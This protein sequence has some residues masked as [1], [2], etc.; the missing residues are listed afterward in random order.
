MTIKKGLYKIF[1][2]KLFI[3][4]IFFLAPFLLLEIIEHNIISTYKST[5]EEDSPSLAMFIL[6]TLVWGGTFLFFQYKRKV[7]G[8]ATLIGLNAVNKKL[9]KE[10]VDELQFKVVELEDF[11]VNELEEAVRELSLI[12]DK[13]PRQKWMS[14]KQYKNIKLNILVLEEYINQKGGNPL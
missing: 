6:M 9:E 7:K 11:Q 1:Y 14:K 3:G 5:S 13:N 12:R 10:Y 2:N 8:F 4:I